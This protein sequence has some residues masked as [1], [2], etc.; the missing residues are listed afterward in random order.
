MN[1]VFWKGKKVFLTGHTGFKGTWLSAW[2]SHLGAQIKGYALE[3]DKDDALF[4]TCSIS[5]EIDSYIGDIRDLP[6]LKEQM[7]AFNPDI[8]IHM[9]AQPLVRHSYQFPVETF[10]T[11]VMSFQKLQKPKSRH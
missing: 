1:K 2:L 5:K 7:K 11:N 3:A 6:T 8:V 9:A 4:K 10:S